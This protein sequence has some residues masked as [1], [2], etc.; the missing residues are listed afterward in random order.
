[1]KNIFKIDGMVDNTLKSFGKIVKNL[2]NAIEQYENEK[3]T[4]HSR[5]DYH[6]SQIEHHDEIIKS[7]A[8]KIESTKVIKNKIAEFLPSK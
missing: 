5:I 8:S 2:N 3:L 4:S 7:C 6:N 1:M